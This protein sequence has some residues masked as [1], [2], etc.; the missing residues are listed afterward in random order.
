MYDQL[1]RPDAW[2]AVAGTDL[3]FPHETRTVGGPT[4]KEIGFRGNIVGGWSKKLRPVH[5]RT[6][7]RERCN[8]PNEGSGN[9]T[10][11]LEKVGGLTRQ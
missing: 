6:G 1:V 11:N 2:G 5:G 8:H 10:D 3:L 7:N 4:V 9:R